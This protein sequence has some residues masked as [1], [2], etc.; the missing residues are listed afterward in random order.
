MKTKHYL[1]LLTGSAL[2]LLACLFLTS[3]RLYAQDKENEHERDAAEDHEMG[4][5]HKLTLV[6]GGGL[7]YNMANGPYTLDHNL[8][9][10]GHGYMPEFHAGLE[11]PM[12]THWMFAPRLN[13][14]GFS[15][16]LNDGVPTSP[17]ATAIP[18]F[19]YDARTVGLDLLFKASINRFHILFGPYAGYL[20]K[21]TW[22][23]GTFGDAD[24]STVDLP[25]VH[26]V[27]ITAGAGVGYDAPL[28]HNNTLWLTPEITYHYP[29]T[30]LGA[31]DNSSVN[32]PGPVKVGHLKPSTLRGALS[33]KFD[34]SPAEPP[35]AAAPPARPLSVTVTA[36]GILPNG[37]PTEEPV[38]PEQATRTR[39]SVPLLPY[40]FF[41]DKNAAI[42]ARY[43][44]N[45][46]TG[47]TEAQLAG[48]DALDVNHSLLD[49]LGARMKQYPETHI[50]I[51]GTNS[52]T[53]GERNNITL[54]KGRAM[55]VRDYLVNTWGID[56]SRIT[57]DQRNLPELPTNPVT[58]AGIEENR[59]VEIAST[60]PRITDPVKNE[61]H[62]SEFMGETLVRYEIS[63][64]NP[65]NIPVSSWKLSLDQNGT[66]IGTTESGSGTPPAVLPSKIPDAAHYEGQPVHY[67][68]EVTDIHGQKYTADGTT[69]I[70]RK[71]V[72]NDELEKYAMLSFDFDRSFVNDRAERM[73]AL[74]G[75]SINRDATGVN[76]NGFCDNTGTVEYNQALSEARAQKA[77][78]ALR[79]AARMPANVTVTGHGLNDPKFP[80][81]LPEGRQLNRRVEVDI[82]KSK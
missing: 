21:K 16:E 42:P 67:Q 77:A 22:A 46:A 62:K 65:D 71:T 54:S 10:A 59:R 8:Y 81:D 9:D 38:I 45:G 61:D 29:I 76:I 78:D 64:I 55:A 47:F 56:G 30:N 7:N 69:H 11:I 51:T 24:A 36:K 75:E 52:N 35:P 68:L 3:G 44:R 4:W 70:V 19:A 63:V 33:L 15:A 14:E 5:P 60:D 57:V 23:H 32:D 12:S 74:I 80:N 31:G 18:Q 6:L 49:V 20:I 27:L 17:T 53:G 72:D 25:G 66:V 50:T 28:N 2:A 1:R 48:K 34:I 58:K 39:A 40:V 13:Y 26:R 43:S 41:E 82:A 73:I 37:E 79:A